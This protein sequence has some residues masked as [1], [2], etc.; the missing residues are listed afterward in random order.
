MLFSRDFELVLMIVESCKAVNLTSVC[1][2]DPVLSICLIST[3]A[4][5]PNH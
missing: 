4:K 5:M 3:A 1:S 2:L